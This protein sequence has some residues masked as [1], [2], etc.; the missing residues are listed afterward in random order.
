MAI[1]TSVLY[2]VPGIA[3]LNAFNDMIDGHYVCF[4]SRLMDAI[5]L[6]LL[7]V[8]LGCAWAWQ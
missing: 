4:F 1:A 5:V 8:G 3:F 6:Y 7:P 2:L